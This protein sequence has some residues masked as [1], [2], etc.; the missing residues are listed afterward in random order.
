MVQAYVIEC[1]NA[2]LAWDTIRL[3][4]VPIKSAWR[5]MTE[6]Y[7]ELVKPLP[8]IR[9]APKPRR[10]IECLEA[11]EVSR[12]LEWLKDNAPAEL[13]GMATLQALCGLRMLEAQ[14]LR[15]Q[16]VDLKAGTITIT[17]TDHHKPKTLDSHRTIPV[18]REALAALQSVMDRQRVIPIT[19]EIFSL[20]RRARL[21]SRW[22]YWLRKAA[23]DLDDPR[24][25]D[26]PARKLRASFAT[27]AGRMGAPDRLLKAY[28]GHVPGDML[29]GH[30]R[31]I[32]MD[33]L[34]AVSERMN[35]WRKL[36]ERD[37]SRKDSGNIDQQNV[38]DA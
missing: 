34:R 13:W 26:I 38:A 4:L 8:K 18:C 24:F 16:D 31:R 3:R 36:A 29:G 14:H 5:T 23:K 21:S 32:G 37:A 11:A 30:Y 28:L 19:G 20:V 22:S 17:E 35:G 27:M 33:E 9:T 12:L 15:R 6:N 2:G 10:E 25:R 1:E 7:P